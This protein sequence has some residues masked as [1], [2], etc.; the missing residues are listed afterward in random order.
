[1]EEGEAISFAEKR[2]TSF[3]LTTNRDKEMCVERERMDRERERGAEEDRRMQ[4]PPCI[5][6]TVK[7]CVAILSLSLY[8]YMK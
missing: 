4:I 5:D 6:P 1:M 2:K 7:H 8:P 3:S